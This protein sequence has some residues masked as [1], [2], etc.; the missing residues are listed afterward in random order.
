LKGLHLKF[1][2]P[3]A[4][5]LLYNKIEK[6]LVISDLHIGWE[7]RLLKDGV[8]IPSQTGKLLK[9]LKFLIHM[10]NPDRL[11]IL[12]D[13][14]HTI[15]KIAQEEWR[16][17]PSFLEEVLGMSVKT[18]IIPGNHDG[19]LDALLPDGIEV[20]SSHGIIIRNI[21]LFHG[22]TLPNLSM[23]ECN[24]LI[25]GHVH[26]VFAFK[27]PLGFNIMKQVWVRAPCNG[28]TLTRFLLKR[29]RTKIKKNEDPKDILKKK[30][31]IE[32]K[33]KDLLIIPSFNDYL[34]GQTI[35]RAAT[36]RKKKTREFISPILRSGSVKIKEAEIFLLDRTFLGSVEQVNGLN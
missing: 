36:T 4:A 3:Y 26:P 24:T 30:F 34:G 9:K 7:D 25:I 33:V 8:N 27:D 13:I 2:S 18:Q 15:A 14:K 28:K 5:L 10:V 21:G 6:V 29:H 23:L 11:V 22:H 12:G 35:N 19:I 17:I 1:L 31:N 32:L 16:D 20:L